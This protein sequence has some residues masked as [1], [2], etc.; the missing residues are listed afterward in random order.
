MGKTCG[1]TTPMA[2][3]TITIEDTPDGRI[4][5]HSSYQPS[6]G[7]RCSLAQQ[8]TLEIVRRTRKEYGLSEP[9]TVTEHTE[10]TG[11][12]ACPRCGNA[13]QVWRNQ[14]SG[15]IKCHRAHCDTVIPETAQGGAV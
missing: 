13:R 7:E 4:A 12:P 11:M 10:A 2:T 14:I 8:A 6:R 15:Q 5:V 3:T 1:A 9:T